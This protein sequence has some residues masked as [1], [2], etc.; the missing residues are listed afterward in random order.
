M[1]LVLRSTC[2]AETVGKFGGCP[3]GRRGHSLLIMM[4]IVLTYYKGIGHHWAM[5]RC[6]VQNMQ[7]S[8]VVGTLKKDTSNDRSVEGLS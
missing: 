1:M 2:I 6:K 3:L 5:L 7:P 4:R 8:I